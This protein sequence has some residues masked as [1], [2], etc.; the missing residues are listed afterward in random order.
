MDATAIGAPGAWATTGAENDCTGECKQGGERPQG[1]LPEPF[2]T[3]VLSHQ[4]DR[5]GQ[6]YALRQ[7]PMK[8]LR[9]VIA[10]DSWLVA[11]YLSGELTA[12]GHAVVGR[13][14]TGEELISLVAHQRPDLVL[15]DVRLADGADGLA[16]AKEV[17]ERFG[18][19]AIAATGH[20]TPAE[21]EAAGLLGI[22]S[23]P[24]TPQSLRVVVN[25][26]AAWLESGS[27][28]PFLR[29]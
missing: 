23:K 17:Q 7:Y 8:P 20:L 28:R 16:A 2:I 4:G 10:E 26:A 22:L 11:E 1:L 19:P 29:R 25:R 3:D 18:I 24:Y 27:S 21:A 12:L 15:A 13:A 6:P 5:A 14:K 9:I